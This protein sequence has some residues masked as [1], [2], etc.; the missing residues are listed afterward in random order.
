MALKD[1]PEYVK[2]DELRA[3]TI[4]KF[5]K[6]KEKKS[7]LLDDI[8]LINQSITIFNGHYESVANDYHDGCLSVETSD[9]VFKLTGIYAEGWA[10]TMLYG[11]NVLNKQLEEWCT[12]LGK[13]KEKIETA[14]VVKTSAYWEYRKIEEECMEKDREKE[15]QEI[16]LTPEEDEG[17]QS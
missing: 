13:L 16:V 7:T 8:R 6:L 3:F 11:I 9:N 2:A 1:Y 14:D 15:E 5:N 4:E 12:E 17:V 10:D